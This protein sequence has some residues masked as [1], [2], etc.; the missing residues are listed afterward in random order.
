M[1]Y[2]V[3]AVGADLLKIG[4][5]DGKPAERIRQLQTGC[6]HKLRLVA[7]E[8]GN[9]L[10]EKRLHD[11][12]SENRVQG[13]WFRIDER[14]RWYLIWLEFGREEA[15]GPG[16]DLYWTVDGLHHRLGDV[17]WMSS[18]HVRLIDNLFAEVGNLYGIINRGDLAYA[19]DCRA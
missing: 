6:P 17:E 4:F 12:W 9:E 10:K 11:R 18:Q 15:V 8:P 1:I 14:M 2:F 3:E 16:S 5:T 7:A 19:A 13:E